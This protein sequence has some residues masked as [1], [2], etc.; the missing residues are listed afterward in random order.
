MTVCPLCAHTS[1]QEVYAA[2]MPLFHLVDKARLGAPNLFAPMLLVRCECC[3]HLFNTAFDTALAGRMYGDSPL[4]NVPVSVSMVQSLRDIAD[5]IGFGIYDEGSV[6]E[7]GGGSGH[8]ARILA[9]RAKQVTVFEPCLGLTSELLPE[10][11]VILRNQIFPP[12][13]PLA[14]CDLVVCR[15]VIEHVAD[16]LGVMRAICD[17]LAV[18]GYAYLEVPRVEFI[19]EK[20]AL[21]DIHLWHVQYFS[22]DN[23]IRAAE[24]VGLIAERQLVIKNGHD[25]G[26]LFKKGTPVVPNWCPSGNLDL[27][28]AL[29]DSI[30][31]GRLILS[32][33]L[34][35]AYLYGATAHTAMFLNGLDAAAY[36]SACVDDNPHNCGYFLFT[37]NGAIPVDSPTLVQ[38]GHPDTIVIAAYLHDL[39]IAAKL[40]QGGFNGRLL[41]IRPGG[42]SPNEFGL[43][44]IFPQCFAI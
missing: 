15:Q 3:G 36:F 43:E 41:S 30:D 20:A 22:T 25:I 4:T 31:A 14:P 40:R 10:P 12:P 8:M 34:G 7:I 29:Q 38:S 26:V 6:V 35:S 16:P 17:G 18:G 42:V 11:N 21:P 13:E 37:E 24:S 44:G 27:G 32:E 9:Q 1:A 39:G 2:S 23:F 33:S 5:W 28:T 19:E